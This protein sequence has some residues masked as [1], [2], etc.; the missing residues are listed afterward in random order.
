MALLP[1]NLS[2]EEAAAVPVGA[3]TARQALFVQAGGLRAGMSVLV[4]GAAGAVGWWVVQ[5]AKA[6]VGV[7]VWGVCGT[8]D[9][10][11]LEGLGVRVIGYAKG[12][13]KESG[14]KVDVVIDTAMIN[15]AD[16][17]AALKD[18][19]LLLSVVPV[20]DGEWKWQLERPEGVSEKTRGK[21]FIMESNGEHLAKITELI[22]QGQARS[23]VDSVFKLEEYKKAFERC[24]GRGTNGRVVIKLDDFAQ[25][26]RIASN[27]VRL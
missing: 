17:W 1:N 26:Q 23:Q 16:S 13:I 4:N 6:V 11:R 3:K 8:R 22:K 2:W 24:N 7:E 20:E 19:G 18:G 21:F 14:V 25:P 5:L 10:E 12:S 27:G 9:V 15:S